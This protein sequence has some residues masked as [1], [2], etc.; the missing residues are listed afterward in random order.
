MV[1][2]GMVMRTRYR[3]ESYKSRGAL[4]PPTPCCI[5]TVCR[6]QRQ[7]L[8]I[9]H[10][11]PGRPGRPRLERP[12]RD[13]RAPATLG[14]QGEEPRKPRGIPQI[15][16]TTRRFVPD[17]I[18]RGAGGVGGTPPEGEEKLLRIAPSGRAGGALCA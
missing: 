9:E 7:R 4:C 1:P 12:G 5:R 13:S 14:E 11:A 16:P 8:T 17:S 18:H 2:A 15:A 3:A 6:Q 10:R